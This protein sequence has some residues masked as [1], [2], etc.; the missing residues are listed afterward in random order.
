[1]FKRS[2][3]G[4]WILLS[5]SGLLCAQFPNIL[6]D[7]NFYPEEPSIT[8][9]PLNVLQVAAGSN[10]NN[11]YHSTD[12]GATWI[13]DVISS[14]F[15]AAGD[16]CLIS[17]S[18]GSIFYFHLANSLD[19]IVCQRSVDGGASYD[20]GSFAW[21]NNSLLQDKE[22]A[23]ADPNTGDLFVTWTQYDNGSN[24]GPNDSSR[25]YF[26]RSA[27]H[28]Q[29]FSNAVRLNEFAGDCLWLDITDPHPFVGI[30]G[31]IF[32]TFMDSSGIR[33]NKS[34]DTGSTWLPSQPLIAAGG[35]FRYN[36]V[37]GITRIRAMPFS[38][39]DRSGSPYRGNLY[40]SWADQR[41]GANNSDIFFIKSTDNGNSWT[42]PLIVNTDNT[43]RHQFRN[44][45]TVDPT[46]GYIYLVYYDR[47]N[48]INNDSTD[49]YL[50]KSTDGG[51]T[52]MDYKIS[53]SGF[54]SDGSTFDG[55]YIDIAAFD[56][57]IRPIWTRID[58]LGSSVWTCLF[59]EPFAGL[60]EKSSAFASDFFVN[61]N[62]ANF[63]AAVS[64]PDK[65]HRAL[66]SVMDLSGRV[67]QN[68]IVEDQ[69][70]KILDLQFVPAGL[71]FVSVD[72]ITR[73]LVVVK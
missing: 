29:T 71:Y 42:S 46:N 3:L 69:D 26:S 41:N 7:D 10:I 21:N 58:T 54:Y 56:G 51:D 38:A 37:P 8:I 68:F 72:G 48:Y 36:Q 25:I 40:V 6:I 23:A 39:C 57:H 20:N 60:A 52:W 18:A 66:G 24:P 19:K 11:A 62:P 12:G 5:S 67:V 1:M 47:R 31:E 45:M 61:P 50:A 22:W 2:L 32:V 70:V 30:H 43:G 15:T 59:D 73:R 49:V 63:F 13:T 28:G 14:S 64:F 55:D 53:S 16:P 34:L 9:N 27:D 44:A 17:D 65:V 33:L 35:E 4:C